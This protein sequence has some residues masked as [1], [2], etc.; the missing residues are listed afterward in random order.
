[1]LLSYESTGLILHLPPLF[2]QMLLIFFKGIL[3]LSFHIPSLA[4]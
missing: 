3:G 4:R 2:K 1:M